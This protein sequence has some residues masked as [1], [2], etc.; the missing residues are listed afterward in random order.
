MKFIYAL[1]GLTPLAG[2]RRVIGFVALG[3]SALIRHVLCDPAVDAA[4]PFLATTCTAIPP[5]ILT[6][7]EGIGLWA[8]TAGI[9]K[10][11]KKK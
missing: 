11:A 1:L 2:Y 6:V 7:L 4:L 9:L 5:A 10:A 8:G 3:G